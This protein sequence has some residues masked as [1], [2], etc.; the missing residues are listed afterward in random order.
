MSFKSSGRY[1]ILE[2]LTHS[3]PLLQSC[4]SN[5][6]GGFI[7]GLAVERSPIK[8]IHDFTHVIPNKLTYS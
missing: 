7:K 1:E 3:V 4:E 6:N 8:F 5:K 2:M